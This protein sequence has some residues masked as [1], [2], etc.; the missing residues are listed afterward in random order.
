[1]KKIQNIQ[2]MLLLVGILVLGVGLSQKVHAYPPGMISCSWAATGCKS[3]IGKPP[4]SFLGIKQEVNVSDGWGC[5]GS[6]VINITGVTCT[7]DDMTGNCCS[8]TGNLCP[9]TRVCPC[10]PL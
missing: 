7:D 5:D 8:I 6:T 1:M 3:I 10:P 9:H 4:C 2:N